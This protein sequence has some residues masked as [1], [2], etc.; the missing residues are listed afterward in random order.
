MQRAPRT[1]GRPSLPLRRK[2]QIVPAI[3]NFFPSP[4]SQSALSSGPLLFDCQISTVPKWKRAKRTRGSFHLHHLQYWSVAEPSPW[5][6]ALLQ[7]SAVVADEPSHQA[8]PTS[9]AAGFNCP[10]VGSRSYFPQHAKPGAR[11]TFLRSRFQISRTSKNW[12]NKLALSSSIIHA[13]TVPTSLSLGGNST[14]GIQKRLD[15]GPKLKQSPVV[16]CATKSWGGPRGFLRGKPRSLRDQNFPVRALISTTFHGFCAILGVPKNVGELHTPVG[17]IRHSPENVGGGKRIHTQTVMKCNKVIWPA[18][19]LAKSL[20]FFRQGLSYPK[21]LGQVL[22]RYFLD[23]RLTSHELFSSSPNQG[24]QI[25]FLDRF[26]LFA[27]VQ[28]KSKGQQ[29]IR[30]DGQASGGTKSSQTKHE[31]K[32]TESL[33]MS[34]VLFFLNDYQNPL[35]EQRVVF[36]GGLFSKLK[37]SKLLR[38]QENKFVDSSC[39]NW[40]VPGS[41]VAVEPRL[42]F[43]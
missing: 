34:D 25:I 28:K 42:E 8:I 40:V 21:I 32:M 30:A 18:R 3:S 36:G 31:N 2:M 29:K 43:A 19:V 5:V 12:R 10:T 14:N 27:Y 4:T 35:E 33:F 37:P 24:P 15:G 38:F 41:H 26:C 6:G 1:V 9:N 16:G 17:C 13:C 23:C 11:G 20:A 7:W 22:V 39:K